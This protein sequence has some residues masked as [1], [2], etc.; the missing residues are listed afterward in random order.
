MVSEEHQGRG[1]ALL[2]RMHGDELAVRS[3][4]CV[5][6]FVVREAQQDKHHRVEAD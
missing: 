5:G 1:L 2:R 6:C 4:V 3:D